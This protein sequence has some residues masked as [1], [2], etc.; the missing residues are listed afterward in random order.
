MSSSNIS[1]C[2]GTHELHRYLYDDS[3][4]V[5]RLH[6]SSQRY[7]VRLGTAT[8]TQ[9]T[10]GGNNNHTQQKTAGVEQER[11]DAAAV[12]QLERYMDARTDPQSLHTDQKDQASESMLLYVAVLDVDDLPDLDP[13]SLGLDKTGR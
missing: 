5:D 1:P 12:A 9:V 13:W 6:Q 2:S 11:K 7:P 3:N 4:L 8:Q 10:A